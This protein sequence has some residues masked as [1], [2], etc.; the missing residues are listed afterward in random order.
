MAQV[1]LPYD[2][3]A[4]RPPLSLS[5]GEKR[6]VA[7]AGVLAMQPEILILDEPTAGLD[8]RGV[9]DLIRILQDLHQQGTTLILI[10]HDMDLAANLATHLI[11]LRQGKVQLAGKVHEIF[12]RSDFATLSGLEPPQAIQFAQALTARGVKLPD[13]IIHYSDIF[14][15]FK[16]T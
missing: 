1:G 11:L 16:T 3:F 8:P 13:H 6:R 9:K 2:D 5:G 7:L 12:S 15:L 4:H 10:T 14:P